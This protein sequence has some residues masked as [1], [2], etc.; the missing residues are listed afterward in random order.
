M[1]KSNS[2]ITQEKTAKSVKSQTNSCPILQKIREVSLEEKIE[3]RRKKQ[4]NR[5]LKREMA[6]EKRRENIHDT[7]G[8]PSTNGEVATAGIPRKKQPPPPPKVK[9]PIRRMLDHPHTFDVSQEK[10]WYSA[11]ELKVLYPWLDTAPEIAPQSKSLGGQCG[12]QAHYNLLHSIESI[13]T[14]PDP[15][16]KKF[17]DSKEIRQMMSKTVSDQL[18]LLETGKIPLNMMKTEHLYPGDVNL[19]SFSVSAFLAMG[20][21]MNPYRHKEMFFPGGKN[22]GILWLLRQ[23]A[24]FFIVYGN[25]LPIEDIKKKAFKDSFHYLAVNIQKRLIIDN[26]S[27]HAFVRLSQ[28]AFDVRLK[29]LYSILALEKQEGKEWKH[30]F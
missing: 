16:Q 24:G 2:K 28:E 25:R 12:Y 19:K 22:C 3:H 7:L 5:K 9:A 17:V 10:L 30:V 13:A 21:K 27:S 26:K 20:G 15:K 29:T 4:A 8:S 18:A 6:K 11:K 14:N 1:T 23:E